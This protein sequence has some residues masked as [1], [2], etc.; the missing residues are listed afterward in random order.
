MIGGDRLLSIGDVF[1][2]EV[3]GNITCDNVTY[4]TNVAEI[5]KKTF[6]ITGFPFKLHYQPSCGDACHG[7]TE[8]YQQQN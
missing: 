8:I 5:D 3:K 2:I 6:Q 1:Q 7:W 4:N